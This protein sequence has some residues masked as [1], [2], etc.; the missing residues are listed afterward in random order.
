MTGPAMLSTREVAC[1][2]FGAWRMA[3][4][5]RS[6]LQYFDDT[7]AGAARSFWVAAFVLPAYAI[8]LLIQL[9]D[10]LAE[11]TAIRFLTVEAIAYVISWTATPLVV[12]YI[13]GMLDRQ[14]RY[15][16]WLSAYNWSNTIQIAVYLPAVLL[17]ATGLLGE[18]LGETLVMLVTLAVFVYLWFI[19]RT[20]LDISGPA[21]AGIVAIAVVNSGYARSLL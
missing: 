17:A 18:G 12:W 9:W 6:A 16:A 13:A 4:F 10:V 11:T 5:D 15:F 8:L 21:S 7:P 20:A 2:L 14:E 1:G 3:R 19:A